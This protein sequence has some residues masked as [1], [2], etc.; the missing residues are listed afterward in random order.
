LQGEQAAFEAE[1]TLAV[2]ARRSDLRAKALEHFRAAA[3]LRPDS[4]G[5]LSDIVIE[6]VELGRFDEA[7]DIARAITDKHP[8]LPVGYHSLARIARRR[9]Q[10]AEALE[11][12]RAAAARASDDGWIKGEIAAVLRELGR[13]DE[14]QEIARA[15]ADKWPDLPI[16]WRVLGAVARARGQ[17]EEALAHFQAAAR[18]DAGDLWNQIEIAALLRELGRLDEAQE[19]ARAVADKRPDLPVGWRLLGADARARGRREEALAHFQAAA[20]IDA[21]NLE[22]QGEIAAVLCELGRLDEAQEIARAVGDKRPDLVVSWRVLGEIARKRGDMRQALEHFRAA[23]ALDPQN[24]WLHAEVASALRELRQFKEAV[25]YAEA[26]VAC[27][28]D[29]A[30]AWTTLAQCSRS[31]RPP[32]EILALFERAVEREPGSLHARQALAGEYV[33]A[34]RLD[35]AERIY[36]A[37]LV[38]DAR[39]VSALV[40]KAQVARRRGERASS[41]EALAMAAKAEPDID[42]VT[43]EYARELVDAGRPGEAEQYLTTFIER[44]PGRPGVLVFL[45]Q[46]ARA[47]GEGEKARR[48]FAA[49]AALGANNDDAVVELAVEDYRAGQYE[50]A[51]QRLQDLLARRPGHARALEILADIAQGLHDAEAAFELRRAALATDDSQLWPRLSLARLEAARGRTEEVDRILAECEAWFGLRPEIALTRAHIERAAG[52]PAKVLELL[53][54]AWAAFPTHFEIWLQLVHALIADGRFEAARRAVAAPPN[55]SERERSRVRFLRGQ[56]AAAQWRLEDAAADFAEAMIA[57]PADGSLHHSAAINALARADIEAVERS[58]AMLTRNDPAHRS[59]H[60]GAWKPL[61]SQ[62]G[63]IL[64][65]YRIDADSL[66]RL[67]AANASDDPIAALEAL[68]RDRSDY[69]AAAIG[70]LIQLRRKGFLDRPASRGGGVSHIPRKIGQYWDDQI[71]PD[72]ERL[73]EEWRTTNP[74]FIYRRFSKADARGFL[75]EFGPPG[76]RKA[77]DLA[78]EPAMKADL[79]RLA[80]LF[81]EGGFYADADDR[82]LKPLDAIAPGNREL[83]LYQEDFG[84]VGN[85]FIGAIPQHPVIAQALAD[86]I[87]AILRGD[88]DLLWLATGPG[89]LTRSLARHLAAGARDRI[90]RVR[91]FDRYELHRAIAMHCASS[92][93]QNGQHWQHWNFG[94]R[95]A[96]RR[97]NSNRELDA[98][99]TA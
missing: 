30:V 80:Y 53:A 41:L 89:L 7:L 16:G 46:I 98:A 19:V 86:A 56:I 10:H 74:D 15:V 91:V 32:S 23:A 75:E 47:Q 83:V 43:V 3:A 12:L 73:C 70:L 69:T 92:Y 49:A 45:G 68:V 39:N 5:N 97:K 60:G 33:A 21:G 38:A 28:P 50:A 54:E 52:N 96:D 59:R 90:D 55:C 11:N 63:Q 62:I 88:H 26:L 66:A 57:L 81:H 6:L 87:E 13:L 36:D 48:Y 76:S 25:A 22:N 34:W 18:I 35:D 37:I 20:R 78:I 65:E 51:R 64:D 24:L 72:I 14:A 4:L 44:N 58:L 79:F 99:R 77:F 85:N 2:A 94:Q 8:D 67:R 29:A 1:R 71:P 31:A 42:W 17:R 93:K 95:R 40:G 82:C 61:Q 27:H 9:G 84:T